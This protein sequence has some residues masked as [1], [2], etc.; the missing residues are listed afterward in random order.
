MTI[1]GLLVHTKPKNIHH[2]KTQL[3]KLS[4]VEVYATNPQGKIVVVV[5]Q[6]NEQDLNQRLFQIQDLDG[7]LNTAMVYH[8]SLGEASV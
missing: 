4:G 8:Y 7:V 3:L 5:E 1:V 2:L 6:Q